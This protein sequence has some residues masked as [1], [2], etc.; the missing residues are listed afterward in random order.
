MCMSVCGSHC[1]LSIKCMSMW[2]EFAASVVKVFSVFLML[3][4]YVSLFLS[5]FVC[6]SLCKLLR[7]NK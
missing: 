7:R 1:C 5:R 6:L 4:V 3:S 2:H